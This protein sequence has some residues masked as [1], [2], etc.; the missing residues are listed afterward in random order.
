[1]TLSPLLNH[2]LPYCDEALPSWLWRLALANYLS[3]PG[4]LL[5]YL[6]QVVSDTTPPLKKILLN[7]R[8]P[9]LFAAL[10]SLTHTSASVVH[11]HTLHGFAHALRLPDQPRE[12]IVL[13]L[14]QAGKLLPE[15]CHPDFYSL[16]FVWCPRCLAQARYVRLHW[17]I[18][19]V[20]C[21][22]A[23]RCWLLDTCPEC[24]RP[25]DEVG[26]LR[27][28]C[29]HCGFHLENVQTVPVPE[30]DLLFRLQTTLMSWLYQTPPPDL[31]FPDAPVNVL[32]RILQGLRYA[33]QRSGED[34]YYHHLPPFI[35]RPQLD[36][37]KLRRLTLYERG[38][39]YSTAFQGLLDWP[40]GFY[41]F[42]D[43][44]R[45]R[46]TRTRTGMQAELGQIYIKW[47]PDFWKHS[48]FAFLQDTCN[49]YLLQ[50][51]SALQLVG[52]KRAQSYPELIQKA[53][54]LNIHRAS[55]LFGISSSSL[56]HL[57]A[58][59]LLTAHR[60]DAY[61]KRIWL[62]R[63]ELEQ[64]QREWHQTLTLND[65]AEL[66][67]IG[68]QRVHDLLE[69][70]LIRRTHDVVSVQGLAISRDSVSGFVEQLK[71]RIVTE[72][73]PTQQAV[74]VVKL[75]LRLATLGMK[76]SD[77]LQRILDGRLTAHHPDGSGLPLTDLW[78]SPE[79]AQR[80]FAAIKDERDWMGLRE[81][82]AYLGVGRS[83]MQHLMDNG[84]LLPH[85]V[86]VRKY[87]F[88]RTD[89]LAF[90][91]RSVAVDTAA[92]L[93]NVNTDSVYAFVNNDLLHP[94][95]GPRVNGHG[96]YAFDRNELLTWHEYYLLER[97][98]PL[99]TSDVTRLRRLLR[100]HGISPIMRRPRVYLRAPVMD[101]VAHNDLA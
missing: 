56:H 69:A 9:R 76:L 5:R 63:D 99:V 45:Q 98:F 40:Q 17:H 70:G 16:P 77:V 53:D 67:G 95:Y 11:A 79:T 25:V 71:Q 64:L 78:F 54:F 50:N 33:V 15:R 93:L 38:T 60:F 65:T 6:R 8:E 81:V 10:G 52:S 58:N 59:G 90:R 49:T 2:P 97:D 96:H 73:P 31:G 14:N 48:D 30:D 85:T 3:S 74:S 41:T 94:L 66:L 86:F 100:K 83:V 26:V 75:C 91:H 28:Q 89:V 42:L 12:R 72:A 39:L 34:W 47:L 4:L 68:K 61:P 44:Y 19:F 43:A 36:I 46:P 80:T 29:E 57:V 32:L 92:Q 22:T 51:F 101:V 24:H 1:M 27:G 18:P 13:A 88:L 35:S 7:L 20:T 55:D 23:H 87:F 82:Q 21:C 84:Y 62:Q 37:L